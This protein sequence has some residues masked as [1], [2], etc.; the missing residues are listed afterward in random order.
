MITYLCDYSRNL[1]QSIVWIKKTNGR[2]RGQ[3]KITLNKH[4]F[5]NSTC[6]GEMLSVYFA[7]LDAVKNKYTNI[8]VRNDNKAVV[9]LINK[10][11]KPRKHEVKFLLFLVDEL[12]REVKKSKIEWIRREYN[13][14]ADSLSRE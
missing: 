6:S 7:L 14:E 12:R 9:D 8:C 11:T 4:S 2:K 13:K 10:K 5:L 1:K 3:F